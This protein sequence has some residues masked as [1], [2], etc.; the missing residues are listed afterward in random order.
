MTETVQ[1]VTTDA[2]IDEAIERARR[3]EKYDRRVLKAEYSE[4]TDRLQ[5]EF[6]DGAT[7]TIPRRLL[8]GLADAEHKDLSR[9]E[10]LG[11]GTG[12]LWPD[13]DVAHYVPALVQGVYGSEKWM[14]ALHSQRKKVTTSE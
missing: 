14:M 3:Y 5:L 2:E 11:I 13:L 1:V 12:L 7:T 6:D 9:I 8:Q 4:A 10:I